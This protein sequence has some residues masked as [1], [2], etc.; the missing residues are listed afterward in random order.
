MYLYFFSKVLM[1]SNCS[2]IMF[3]C[4]LGSEEKVDFTVL[5]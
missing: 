3:T 1:C 5:K 2:K 4:L